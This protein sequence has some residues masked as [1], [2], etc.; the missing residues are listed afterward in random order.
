MRNRPSAGWLIVGIAA[1]A[2]LFLTIARPSPEG[3]NPFGVG[4]RE[5]RAA[6]GVPSS[7]AK[8]HN[9]SKLALVNYTLVRV[10]ESYVDP[11][12][13]DPKEMLYAALDSVQLNIPE[14]LIE[15]D[16]GR[17]EIK[18]AVNDKKRIILGC[19]RKTP[20]G[21]CPKSSRASFASSKFT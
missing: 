11:S 15:A 1:L 10:R 14:V 19:R 5:V 17:E 9:L 12:R 7:S 21:T 3:L 8:K 13:I 18:I 6:P 16:R 20:R 2:A 4:G